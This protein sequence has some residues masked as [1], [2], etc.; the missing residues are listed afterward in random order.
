MPELVYEISQEKMEEETFKPKFT[1]CFDYSRAQNGPKKE[2]NPLD[3]SEMQMQMTFD[4]T[5]VV[6]MFSIGRSKKHNVE[7]YSVSENN[8]T[9]E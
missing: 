3:S 4:D 9:E 1:C 2:H 6:Y 5:V 7:G 8:T